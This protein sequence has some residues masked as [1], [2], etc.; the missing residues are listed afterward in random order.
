MAINPILPVIIGAIQT[1]NKIKDINEADYDEVTGQFIDLA[2]AEFFK[3]QTDQKKR[4][5][6]NNK[7]Y[8]ATENRYGTNIAEF[9]AK[10]NLFD[11]YDSPL[12]FLK[13]IEAGDA[14]PVEFRKKLTGATKFKKQAFKTTFAQDQ[15][16]A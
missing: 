4:I 14:M 8:K 11:G 3:D 15:T 2:S 1:R 6:K 5:E 16:L 12:N 13:A 7:F 9:A 10:S